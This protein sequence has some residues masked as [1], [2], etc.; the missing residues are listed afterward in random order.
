M[1]KSLT[2]QVEIISTKEQIVNP[3]QTGA[4]DLSTSLSNNQASSSTAPIKA[5]STSVQSQ[6]SAQKDRNISIIAI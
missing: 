2:T 1:V 4:M 6:S 3:E 5:V